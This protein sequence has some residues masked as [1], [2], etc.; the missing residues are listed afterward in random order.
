VNTLIICSACLLLVWLLYAERKTLVRS[1]II[2]KTALSSLFIFAAVV[3]PHADPAYYHYLLAGLLLCLAGDVLL[4][5]PQNL[6]LFGLVSFLFGHIF[7]II[8]FFY[9]AR[10]G[11]WTYWGALITGTVS[12]S[13][14]FWLRPHLG[15]MTAPV[16][17]YIL[18]ITAM[19]CGAWSI[20]GDDGIPIKGKA[21]IFVG[22]TSFY[23]S[24]IFV[25]R[26]RFLKKE[27]INRLAGLPLYYVGQFLLAF[28]AGLV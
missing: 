12:V 22:A 18:V 28:S 9:A 1:V 17:L 2:S 23:F 13:A 14:F 19:M 25:A 7:Y 6:F 3:Q 15:R 26:D 16:L 11:N 10:S 20:L 24:D 21:A 27:F 8:A 4:A 5:L